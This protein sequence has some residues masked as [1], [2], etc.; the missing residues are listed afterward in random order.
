MFEWLAET[1]LNTPY[2]D[3][4]SVLTVGFLMQIFAVVAMTWKMAQINTELQLRLHRLE[5]DLNNIAEKLRLAI[6]LLER[7]KK[8]LNDI[9]SIVNSNDE[10]CDIDHV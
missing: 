2:I 10:T 9:I 3:N 4:S 7:H 6:D 5:Y 8:T 1:T